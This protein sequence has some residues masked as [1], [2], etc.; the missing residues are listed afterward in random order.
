MVMGG[1]SCGVGISADTGLRWPASLLFTG[2]E[3]GVRHTGLR[4][5]RF[6]PEEVALER[7]G[8]LVRGD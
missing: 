8:G 1:E 7:N 2:G 6:F 4:S 3:S 5:N